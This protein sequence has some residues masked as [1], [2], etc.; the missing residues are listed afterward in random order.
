M[1]YGIRRTL[2]SG[3]G[4]SIAFDVGEWIMGY[5]N[6]FEVTSIIPMH[7]FVQFVSLVLSYAYA[8]CL[9]SEV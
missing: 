8:H 4:A 6:F 1:T 2:C 5:K 7:K 9:S 3:I